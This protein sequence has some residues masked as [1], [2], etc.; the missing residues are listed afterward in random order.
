[1]EQKTQA[2]ILGHFTHKLTNPSTPG[3]EI[4]VAVQAMGELAA[5]TLRFFGVKAS[6]KH[7]I[8]NVESTV[9]LSKCCLAVLRHIFS[10]PLDFEDSLCITLLGICISSLFVQKF[11]KQELINVL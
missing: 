8:V 4:A 9:L 3:G 11:L 10:E 5:S 1:V 6:S 2:T 7:D